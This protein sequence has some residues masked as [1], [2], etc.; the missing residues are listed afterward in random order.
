[1]YSD[2]LT[3]QLLKV[4]DLQKFHELIIIPEVDKFNTMGIPESIEVTRQLLDEAIK[5][6]NK[7]KVNKLTY[8]AKLK[9][10][11]DFIGV[12]GIIKSSEKY[13]K[14][15][16]WMKF[17]PKF[18]NNGYATET[19]HTL[20]K[21]CFKEYQLHRVEAGCA[22]ENHASK[23]VLE[24]CGFIMEGIQRK[25]LPLKSG[26]SNNYEFGILEEEWNKQLP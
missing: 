4:S 12:C 6:Q 18:W 3:Y 11:E 20:L 22:V 5:E 7:K 10:T 15:K 8:S 2:R 19:I 14:A 13:A 26:W 25:N 21:A 16:L 17:H 24:K 23:R 9:D 1:L